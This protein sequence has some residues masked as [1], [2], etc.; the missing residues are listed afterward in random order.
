MR[1]CLHEICCQQHVLIKP[2]NHPPWIVSSYSFHCFFWTTSQNNVAEREVKAPF[3]T[4]LYK[5]CLEGG[6]SSHQL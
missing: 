6:V 2:A 4:P 1:Y 3:K 5:Q